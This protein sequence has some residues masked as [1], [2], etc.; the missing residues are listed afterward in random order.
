MKTWRSA[1]LALLV[2]SLFWAAGSSATAPEDVEAHRQCA[3]CGMDRKAFGYSRMLV[4]YED[5]TQVGVCSLHCAMVELVA[6][7]D[8]KVTTLLVA[9]RDTRALLEA[10]KAVWVIGG[11]KP[12]VMTALPKWAFA[13]RAAADAFIKASGG[14]IVPWDEACRAAREELVEKP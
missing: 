6:N 3:R 10:E 2:A 9:D 7:P 4:R 12:G 5:G 8:R 14:K 11:R 1:I 13:S